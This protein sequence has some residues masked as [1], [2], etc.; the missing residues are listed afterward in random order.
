MIGLIKP[1]SD[2][3]EQSN[4]NLRRDGWTWVDGQV[5]QWQKW[6][7]HEPDFGDECA[8]IGTD[9]TWNGTYPRERHRFICERKGEFDL[10]NQKLSLLGQ[11]F[12]RGH[13]AIPMVEY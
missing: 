2:H 3:N 5:Y 4:T 11:A 1:A 12:A 13:R 6:A 10:Y 8:R 7:A 9:G